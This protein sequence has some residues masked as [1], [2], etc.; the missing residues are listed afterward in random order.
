M[1]SGDGGAGYETVVAGFGVG[2]R[3]IVRV[4]SYRVGNFKMEAYWKGTVHLCLILALA[5][6]VGALD[7][8]TRQTLYFGDYVQQYAVVKMML[9]GAT[10]N[11][12]CEDC[13]C[14]FS[15][16]EAVSGKNIV[17]K[18]PMVKLKPGLFGYMAKNNEFQTGVLYRMTNNCSSTTFGSGTV[19]STF[20]ISTDPLHTRQV[21]ETG[22]NSWLSDISQALDDSLSVIFDRSTSPITYVLRK[23]GLVGDPAKGNQGYLDD[24]LAFMK[25]LFSF[26]FDSQVS[27]SRYLLDFLGFIRQLIIHPIDTTSNVIIPFVLN[28][29]WT[30][31]LVFAI[32]FGLLES[33]FIG[34]SV[35]GSN[36]RNGKLDLV[37]LISNM[38]KY[39][40]GTLKVVSGVAYMG[41]L[42]LGFLLKIGID[43]INMLRRLIP[44]I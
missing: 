12:L 36:G 28:A 16:Q 30:V 42:G 25:A 32:W 18:Q 37:L 44:V 20:Q 31:F 9:N 26:L 15:A 35:M 3:R 41:I 27:M 22:G 17:S 7:E 1:G 38:F 39:H 10:N 33:V 23:I 2:C 6:L 43:F 13:V 19:D 14:D 11:V 8:N 4:H 29:L 40:W 21:V 5:G 24:A 34:V